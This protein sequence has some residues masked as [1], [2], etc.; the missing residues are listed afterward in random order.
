MSELL[1]SIIIPVYNTEDFV[2]RAIESAMNQSHSSIEIILVDDG[3]SDR[4]G[5]ICDEYSAKDNRI[6][7]FHQPNRGVSAARNKGLDEASGDYIQFMDSDDEIAPQMTAMLLH[8]IHSTNSD[9]A[10][11]GYADVGTVNIQYSIEAK[12][13]EGK[14]FLHMSYI[15]HDLARMV[16]SSCFML[17]KME[18]IDRCHLR[19]DESW[20]L[21]EDGLFTQSYLMQAAAV[22]TVDQIFYYHHIYDL[23]QR[24]NTVSYF[25]S[26]IYELRLEYFER[27]YE[28]IWD[29]LNA[30]DRQELLQVFFN[31]FIAG[32]VRFG[33][34]LDRYSKQEAR[35]RLDA[36]THN[37]LV[38]QASKLYKRRRKQDSRLIP[39]LIRWRCARL[40]AFVIRSRGNRFVTT[41][42]VNK[43][44]I[45][46]VHRGKQ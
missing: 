36:L 3:S 6:K 7:V 21:G 35:R 20:A 31:Q 34:C 4:S 40:L 22:S 19:F 25:V 16:S 8:S 37:E 2:G 42:E 27:L 30:T 15:Q 39:F 12:V 44:F 43:A 10:I 23:N 26:D 5:I 46:S 14:D 38:N 18:I 17:F 32:L 9:V 24:I 11:C 45:R 1:V 29:R 13:Y 33:V 28:R 41:N